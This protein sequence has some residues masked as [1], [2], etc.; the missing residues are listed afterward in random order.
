[1]IYTMTVSNK[2]NLT[3]DIHMTFQET[4]RQTIEKVDNKLTMLFN[5]A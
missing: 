2:R 4:T 3:K 5:Q 1:M